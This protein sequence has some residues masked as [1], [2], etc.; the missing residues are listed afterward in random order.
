MTRKAIY[1]DAS[2]KDILQR[3]IDKQGSRYFYSCAQPCV[4]IVPE[5]CR[6]A[7]CDSRPSKHQCR[8]C[9]LV[10]QTSYWPTPVSGKWFGSLTP[11]ASEALRLVQSLGLGG[12]SSW[13]AARLLGAGRSSVSLKRGSARYWPLQR[14]SI[15]LSVST[16]YR[17]IFICFWGDLSLS[18][19]KT[20]NR[21]GSI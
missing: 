15:P 14:Q 12:F 3:A 11:H 21:Y 10:R 6:R 17:I 8:P 4:N 13:E 9:Q 19:S 16:I 1:L 20:L 7:F 5:T 2:T 18:L